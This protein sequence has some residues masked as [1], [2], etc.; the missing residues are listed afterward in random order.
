LKTIENLPKR[1]VVFVVDDDASSRASLGRLIRSV[2]LSV[3]LFCSAEHFLTAKLSSDPCC[4]VVGLQEP[5]GL[6]LQAK[7]AKE[8]IQTPIIF[9]TD[10]GDIRTSV[11]AMKAGAVDFLTKPFRDQD[12]LDAIQVALERD[13]VRQESVMA[14]ADLRAKFET[15][16]QREHE[17]M[18]LVTIGLLNKHIAAEIGITVGTVKSLRAKVVRKIGAKSLA[19]LVRMADV[20][21]VRRTAPYSLTPAAG[22]VTKHP[23]LAAESINLGPGSLRDPAHRE[24]ANIA[25]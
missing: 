23:G 1:Y 18:V 4:L 16:T 2:G 19:N 17:V 15:L 20:L 21:K 12:M 8:K 9:T 10:E 25:A 11:R 3:E 7:L 14:L 24:D 5:S 22:T 6:D 13:R